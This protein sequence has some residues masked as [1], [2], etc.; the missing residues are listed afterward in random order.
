MLPDWLQSQSV[1]GQL[2]TINRCAKL[3]ASKD[4]HAEIAKRISLWEVRAGIPEY[5]KNMTA[6]KYLI[7]PH[8]ENPGA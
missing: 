2:S 1:W 4:I 8:Q 5:K 3:I 7:Y 6:G